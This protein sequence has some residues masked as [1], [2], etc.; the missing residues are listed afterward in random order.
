MNPSYSEFKFPQIKAQSWNKVFRSRTP[1]EAIDLISKL[2]VYEPNK[3]MDPIAALLH[4]F[5]NDLRKEGTTLPN[6]N[7]LPILFNF[8]QEELMSI[9]AEQKATIMAQ[10]IP[11]WYRAQQEATGQANENQ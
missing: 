3:R 5:F 9:E 4:P 8:K 1:V 2:L 11:E 7:R 10:L 6:G